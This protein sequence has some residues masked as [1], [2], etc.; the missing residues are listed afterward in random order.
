MWLSTELQET[1]SSAFAG[2]AETGQWHCEDAGGMS[3]AHWS[4]SVSIGDWIGR[5][6]PRPQRQRFALIQNDFQ[7][8]TYKWNVKMLIK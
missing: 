3:L 8:R 5:K 1:H 6:P 2:R 7:L 4:I